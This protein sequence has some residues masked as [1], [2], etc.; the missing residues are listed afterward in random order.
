MVRSKE[1]LLNALKNVVGD[2]TADEVL[3]LLED[4]SDSMDEYETRISESGD[5]KRKY[6]ENDAEWRKRYRERFFG[7]GDPGGGTTYLEVT[8][9]VVEV[10]EETPDIGVDELYK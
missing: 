6:E 10:E 5:W 9:E 2:N 7:N 1:E 8:Q 3:S 4:L